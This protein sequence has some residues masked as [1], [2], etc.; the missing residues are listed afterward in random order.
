M[1][2]KKFKYTEDKPKKKKASR[3]QPINA[4]P[5]DEQI[6]EEN[7]AEKADFPDKEN[8][9]GAISALPLVKK[10]HKGEAEEFYNCVADSINIDSKEK[11]K[12]SS[13]DNSHKDVKSHLDGVDIPIEYLD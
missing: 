7:E 11:L 12:Q 5:F 10:M 8:D 6:S 2:L 1:W 3:F 9:T 13:C 4:V